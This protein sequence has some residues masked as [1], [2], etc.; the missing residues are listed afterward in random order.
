MPQVKYN[1]DITMFCGINMSLV[2]KENKSVH[3]Y[4]NMIYWLNM[5]LK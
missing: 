2:N 3:K 4:I 5:S 1:L